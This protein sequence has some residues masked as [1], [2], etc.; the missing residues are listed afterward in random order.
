MQMQPLMEYRNPFRIHSAN[1]III[2]NIIKTAER[3]GSQSRRFNLDQIAVATHLQV[4]AITRLSESGICVLMERFER[5]EFSG[6]HPSSVFEH[7][8]RIYL[9][10]LTNRFRYEYRTNNNGP[11]E[12]DKWFSRYGII[13]TKK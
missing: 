10:I 6:P 4:Y 13:I 5:G 3:R 12:R 1:I 8:T 7:G 9:Q 11:N 2:F